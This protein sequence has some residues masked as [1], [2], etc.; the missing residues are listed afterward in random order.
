M[1]LNRILRSHGFVAFR[2]ELG[3]ELLDAGASKAF[4]VADHQLAH[5]YVND[6]AD[7]SRVKAIL[8]Q[9]DGVA[10]VLD[11]DGKRVHHI[12]H[13]RAGELVVI[14]EPTAWFT[15]YYWEN[16][17]RAPDFARTVDIHRKPGYDPVEMFIDPTIS[18]VKPKL[19]ATLLK[20][21]LGFRTLMEF[22]PLD[23]SLVKGSHGCVTT[24]VDE[25]PLLISQQGDY[26]PSEQ[27]EAVDVCGT[28]LSHLFGDGHSKMADSREM[29]EVK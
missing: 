6:P 4:A 8:E 10:Q 26:L 25:G 7:M 21:K 27:I 22:T 17:E 24:D 9:V 15:Y 12:D 20:K 16:D 11:S 1:H 29:T 3:R 19:A 5:V 13:P 23:A 14:A 18:L 28:I 2:E